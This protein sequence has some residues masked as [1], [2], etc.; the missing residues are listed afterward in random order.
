MI[1]LANVTARQKKIKPPLMLTAPV[2]IH[3]KVT[4]AIEKAAVTTVVLCRSQQSP[5]HLR[6]AMSKLTDVVLN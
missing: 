5:L 2:M 6:T 1:K 3:A 4:E